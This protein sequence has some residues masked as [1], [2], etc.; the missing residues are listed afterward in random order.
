[1]LWFY[2]V[3]AKIYWFDCKF[4]IMKLL[5]YEYSLKS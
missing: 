1:M 4:L 2:R 3:G 5:K